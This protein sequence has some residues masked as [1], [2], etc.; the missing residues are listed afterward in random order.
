M[1][2]KE[3]EREK[4]TGTICAYVRLWVCVSVKENEERLWIKGKLNKNKQCAWTGL[5]I[6]K[7]ENERAREREKN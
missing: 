4:K 1:C 5:K 3:G 2:E 6:R 7:E